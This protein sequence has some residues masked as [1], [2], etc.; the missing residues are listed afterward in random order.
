MIRELNTEAESHETENLKLEIEK[1]DR[2][3]RLGIQLV[4][5]D[6]HQKSVQPDPAK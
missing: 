1:I 6:G 3:I 2:F 5:E 4:E